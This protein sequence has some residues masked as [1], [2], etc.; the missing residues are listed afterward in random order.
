MIKL[1][2]ANIDMGGIKEAAELIDAGALVAFPTETVYGIACRARSDSLG[3]LDRVKGRSA[4]KRFTLHIAQ[5]SNVDT[6][7]PTMKIIARKLIR[8][9][10]PGPVT[11]VFELQRRDIDIQRKKLEPDVFESLYKNGSIGIRCPDHPVAT[12]LLGQ[13][14]NPVVAPSAN[15]T[16]HSPAV[17]G[18]QVLRR[19]SGRIDM[20][21]DAGPSQ[22]GVNSTVVKMSKKGLEILRPGVCSKERLR[23]LSKVKFL[24]VCTGNTCRSPMAEGFC[25]KY[26]AEKLHAHIDELDQIGYTV[27][28]AGVIGSVGFPASPQAVV[29]CAAKGVDLGAHRNKGLSEKLIEE[30]DFIYVMEPAHR[31]K[32]LAIVPSAAGRCLLLEENGRV[33]DPIGHPQSFYDSCAEQ[34][35]KAVTERIDELAI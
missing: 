30:S 3:R 34:I 28:S 2:P 8:N 14:L 5:P 16:G 13:T 9:A 27:D 18:E 23:T 17:N 32:V 31:E 25:K 21:L 4:Q 26:L 1:D 24:F 33:L 15:L 22:Y 10:W 20:L 11:I 7:V 35:Q 12:A 6:Y 19:L 29:A